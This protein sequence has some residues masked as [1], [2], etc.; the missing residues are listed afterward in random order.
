MSCPCGCGALDGAAFPAA[1]SYAYADK[2]DTLTEATL[3]Y[4]FF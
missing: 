4:T 3:I 2:V 1:E